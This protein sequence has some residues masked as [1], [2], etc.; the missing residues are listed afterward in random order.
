M[1]ALARGVERRF[2]IRVDRCFTVVQVSC[3]SSSGAAT[4]ARRAPFEDRTTVPFTRFPQIAGQISAGVDLRKHAQCSTAASAPLSLHRCLS[5]VR[6]PRG[7]AEP[8]RAAACRFS[9]ELA[10]G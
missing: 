4:S 8:N 7:R 10:V 5:A 2:R 1:N 3:V 6:A 9:T